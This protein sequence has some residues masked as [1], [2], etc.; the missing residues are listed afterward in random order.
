MSLVYVCTYW[1]YREHTTVYCN[2]HQY[3]QGLYAH[4]YLCFII[5]TCVFIFYICT[6]TYVAKDQYINEI[7]ERC[8]NSETEL[9]KLRKEMNRVMQEALNVPEGFQLSR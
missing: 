7:E 1:I 8:L 3:M 9:S 2:Y 4:V 5:C 6:C